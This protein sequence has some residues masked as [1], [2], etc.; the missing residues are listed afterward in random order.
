MKEEI[1]KHKKHR[2]I[3][4]VIVVLILVIQIASFIV[5][6]AKVASFELKLEQELEKNQEELEEFFLETINEYN[7]IY[8]T[9]FREIANALS[10]QEEDFFRELALVRTSQ[11]DFS[12]VIED[13]IEGVV[14]VI[15]DRS[16]GTG[17]FIS[18]AGFIITNYHVISR[19]EMIYIITSENERKEVEFIGADLLRDVAVLRVVDEGVYPR[20]ELADSDELRVGGKVIA[21]GNPLGLSFTVTEGIISA[22][23][24]EGPN[25]LREYIQ[26]DVSLNPGNSGGP[27]INT[28]GKVVGLNN[29]K[30]GGGAEGL[31]FALQSNSIE[32]S[33]NNITQEAIN[34]TILE[35]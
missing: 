32:F 8:Q 30:M 25:R 16:V 23:K 14:S 24:R 12:G 22:L 6:S 10:Q 33:V 1:K 18:E 35:E 5:L 28:E 4:Y 29:F 13:T 2:N 26:T 15:T 9:E 19:G 21:I 20:L 7:A 3:L 31:G 34:N 27:L 11:G 17:F